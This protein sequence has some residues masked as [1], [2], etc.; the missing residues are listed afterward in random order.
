MYWTPKLHKEPVGA[1]FIIASTT[2]SLKLLSKDITMIFRLFFRM[3]QKYNLKTRIWSGVKK[4]WIIQ[5]SD[6]L[7]QTI[8]R[9]NDRKL[10]KTVTTFDFS[11]LYTKIP[12]NLLIEALDEIIDFVF[13]G[14][15][16]YYISVDDFKAVWV[17]NKNACIGRAYTKD[18]IKQGVRYLISNA[19]FSGRRYC[20][21]TDYRYPH[22]LRPCPIFCEP[23]PIY[24]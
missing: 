16:A 4:F 24:L 19:F 2:C 10:A 12:H 13:R 11:T 1:R 21:P 14:G 8:N 9:I 17:K 23:V 15:T 18:N 5:N 20:I 7:I 6:S 22:G 3:V